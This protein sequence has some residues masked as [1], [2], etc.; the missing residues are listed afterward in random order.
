MPAP[1]D[2]QGRPGRATRR[3]GRMAGTREPNAHEARPLCGAGGAGSEHLLHWC[4][5]VAGAWED[6]A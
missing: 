2:A 1:A 6:L 3:A 5:A 4:P